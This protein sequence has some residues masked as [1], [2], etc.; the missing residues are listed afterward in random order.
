M[1]RLSDAVGGRSSAQCPLGNGTIGSEGPRGG[2]GGTPNESHWL[3]DL[4]VTPHR[5]KGGAEQIYRPFFAGNHAA[6]PREAAQNQASASGVAPLNPPRQGR[7]PP[8]QTILN[9]LEL[10]SPPVQKVS[11]KVHSVQPLTSPIPPPTPSYPLAP[12]SIGAWLAKP[13]EN[14]VLTHPQDGEKRH[15]VRRGGETSDT[16]TG[17]TTG[18]AI[19]LPYVY[20]DA[21]AQ[22]PG[23]DFRTAPG[24]AQWPPPSVAGTVTELPAG[25]ASWS[26]TEG[27]ETEA[28]CRFEQVPGGTISVRQNLPAGVHAEMEAAGRVRGFGG[29][30]LGESGYW[31]EI[32][33]DLKTDGGAE[34]RVSETSTSR[35]SKT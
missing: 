15:V 17:P 18:A 31:N 2:G 32:H 24:G 34:V 13:S 20:A 23:V 14:P 10:L 30:R 21:Q 8:S 35:I 7:N 11:A 12:S 27:K 3:A 33:T 9:P 4:V 25:G 16:R 1:R 22:A 6:N 28:G 5:H 29:T 26:G 19:R